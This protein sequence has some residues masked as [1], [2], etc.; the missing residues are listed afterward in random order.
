MRNKGQPANGH[1]AEEDIPTNKP[2]MNGNVSA[3]NSISIYKFKKLKL[4]SIT[5]HLNLFISKKFLQRARIEMCYHN[6]RQWWVLPP[7]VI[8]WIQKRFLSLFCILQTCPSLR[9]SSICVCVQ[10]I[11]APQEKLSVRLY[12]SSCYLVF[13]PY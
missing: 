9:H 8:T 2:L 3:L 7:T 6:E 11:T 13:T 4:T 5:Y 10:N 1:I 12:L